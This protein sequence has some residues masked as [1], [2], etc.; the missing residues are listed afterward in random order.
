MNKRTHYKE[1][2]IK[3]AS[4]NR[5]YLASYIE[6]YMQF[7]NID[8]ENIKLLLG[9]SEDNYFKLCVC[10]AP[11]LEA[12][13]FKERIDKIAAATST[14]SLSI[15]RIL[16]RVDMLQSIGDSDVMLMAARMKESKNE[17]DDE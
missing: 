4:L 7:E 8:K 16:K 6:R 9:C 15:I 13:D 12:E 11:E 3:K 2:L 14:S 17:R 10:L 5:E 1:L